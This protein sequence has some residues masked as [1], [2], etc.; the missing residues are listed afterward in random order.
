MQSS[1]F[2]KGERVLNLFLC[3]PQGMFRASDT[4]G[5]SGK[6]ATGIDEEVGVLPMPRVRVRVRWGGVG[7]LG[8]VGGLVVPVKVTECGVRKYDCCDGTT[9]Y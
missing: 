8:W 5:D 9:P 1:W 7:G 2:E 4:G 3:L 6:R